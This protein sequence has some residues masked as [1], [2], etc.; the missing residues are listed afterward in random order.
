MSW[1]KQT[2][3]L[4]KKLKITSGFTK[5]KPQNNDTSADTADPTNTNRF[6]GANTTV[7]HNENGESGSVP[8]S[9]IGSGSESRSGSVW[10]CLSR[11]LGLS[12]SP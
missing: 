12:L 1:K 7:V 10:S 11:F 8:G 2:K 4:M 6:D 9:G 5:P 3:S